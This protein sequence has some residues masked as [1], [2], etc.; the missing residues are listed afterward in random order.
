MATFRRSLA[1][2]NR[3]IA[4]YAVLAA[5]I[6]AALI[7]PSRLE[8]FWHWRQAQSALSREDFESARAHLATCQRSRPNHARYA[9]ESARLARREKDFRTFNTVLKRAA[10]L[11]HPATE[12]RLEE[13]LSTVQQ[14]GWRGNDVSLLDQLQRHPPEE[15]RIREVLAEAYYRDY[16]SAAALEQAEAW[17]RIEDFSPSAWLLLGDIQMRLRNRAGAGDAYREAVARDPTIVRARTGYAAMLREQGLP[18]EA[19][20][21]YDE[22]IRLRPRDREAQLGW[23]RCQLELNRIES[24]ASVVD[25]LVVEYP[26]DLEVAALKGQI[27]LRVGQLIIAEHFLRCAAR[28]TPEVQVLN[29][30]QQA[31]ARQNKIVEARA[32]QERIDTTRKDLGRLAELN[33]VAQ[34]SLDPAPRVEMGRILIRN[35]LAAEGEALLYEAIRCDPR[36][37][38]AHAA[39]AEHFANLGREEQAAHHRRLAQIK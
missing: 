18:N 16:S 38:P 1:I 10:A 29:D 26:N 17:V 8:A 28:G 4:L 39:L 31:L 3:R 30:L 7:L 21:Q 2:G 12:I 14:S 32:L 25:T 11:G 24:A 6:A 23:V 37:Q 34:R 5:L 36:F 20:E 22:A 13:I 27:A 9:F 15:A 19:A 35:G 33:R